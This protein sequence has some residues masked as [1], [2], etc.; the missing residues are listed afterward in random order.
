MRVSILIPYF[1]GRRAL[2]ERTLWLLRN[3]TYDDYEVWILDDGSDEKIEELCG[4]GILYE[5]VRNAGVRPRAP[6]MAWHHG[7]RLCDGEFV[8]LTHPEY[9]PPLDAIERMVEQYDGSARME[10]VAFAIPPKAMGQ[11]ERIDWRADLDALQQIRDFW[12]FRTPWGWTNME[13][14]TWHHH[15]AFTGQ[16]R[17]AW[18]LHGFMPVTEQRGMNDSWLVKLE[19]QAGRPPRNA[20]FAVYHQHHQRTT[21]WP[22]RE[23]S[24]R[25]R[26]IEQSG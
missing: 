12:T 23:K 2:L 9:M 1:Q 21:E 19:V 6:N 25:L 20:G 14:K 15:F 8:V 4:D 22:F 11:L 10:P 17:R 26:R 16:T 5:R 24:A 18:D 13:A 3:Q 7:Y